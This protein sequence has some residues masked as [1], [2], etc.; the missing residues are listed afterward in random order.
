[1][2]SSKS[3]LCERL[4]KFSVEGKLATNNYSASSI[5]LEVTSWGT[6]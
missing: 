5:L 6:E 4:E 3:K 1:M 2:T